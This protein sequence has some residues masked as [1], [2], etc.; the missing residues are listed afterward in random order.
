MCG[1]VGMIG[2]K[3]AA[4]ILIEGLKRLE[5]RGY[6]SAGV[7]TLS[8]GRIDRRRAEGKGEEH[9]TDEVAAADARYSLPA[10]RPRGDTQ[11]AVRVDTVSSLHLAS[12]C[13]TCC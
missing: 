4:P 3:D 10:G 7:A 2:K 13:V 1:I 5:Y 6:D 11:A 8:D 9:G 12:S